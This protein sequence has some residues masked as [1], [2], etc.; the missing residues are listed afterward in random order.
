DWAVFCLYKTLP[1][2]NGAVLVQNTTQIDSLER[3]ALRRVGSASLLGRAA[4]LLVQRTRCR[5]D[6][7]GAALCAM[8][9]GLGRAAG[10]L[11]VHRT[12][13]GD[14]G[15]DMADVDLAMSQMS[16]RLIARLNFAEI[17]S[18]RLANFRQL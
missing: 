5:V 6:G 11:E 15:F 17:R 4:E 12:P 3:L 2:P 14:M 10:A 8:K 7:L 16:E 13:V 9:R 1:V 18:R